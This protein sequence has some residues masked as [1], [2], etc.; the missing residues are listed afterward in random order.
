MRR[1]ILIVED[2]PAI[3]EAYRL[4]LEQEGYDIVTAENGK[5]ALAK[6]KNGAPLPHLILLDLMMPVMNGWE[7]LEAR[8]ADRALAEVPVVALTC[9]AGPAPLA[10][11]RLVMDKP[12]DIS[13]LTTLVRMHCGD[14]GHAERK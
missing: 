6:L 1:R 4:V 2:D 5:D 11:T 3:C 12:M 7:F 14:A 8:R 9:G 10:D 13:E